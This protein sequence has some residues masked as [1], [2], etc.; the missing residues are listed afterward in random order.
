MIHLDAESLAEGGLA[1][2]Y[3]ELLP[4][5]QFFVAE[6]IASIEEF[7]ED[8]GTQKA[9]AGGQEY[10]IWSADG[11]RYEGWVRAPIALFDVVNRSLASASV[12]FYAFYGGNDLSGMFLTEAQ[13]AEARI[14][15]QRRSDWPYLLVDEPP[16]YGFPNAA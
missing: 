7:A 6:P 3:A 13:F 1:T 4:R 16:H 8:D 15:I 9:R 10:V 12:R 2:A 5:I 11:E 14:A